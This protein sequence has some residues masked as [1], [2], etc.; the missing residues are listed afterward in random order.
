MI[1]RA[2]TLSQNAFDAAY[3]RAAAFWGCVP[4]SEKMHTHADLHA[5]FKSLPTD[6]TYHHV[7]TSFFLDDDFGFMPVPWDMRWQALE[8]HIEAFRPRAVVG[9][10]PFAFE[11]D[12]V[13]VAALHRTHTLGTTVL[14]GNVPLAQEMLRKL[15][16]EHVIATFGT[17]GALLS[18][19]DMLAALP[20]KVWQIVV[21]ADEGQAHTQL[22]GTV[23]KDLHVVPGH[24]IA[25][26]CEHLKSAEFH[27]SPSYA[28]HVEGGEVF[29]TSLEDVPAPLFRLRALKGAFS[30]SACRC[31]ATHTLTLI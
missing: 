8:R 7:P 22:P 27:P 16:A 4:D 21:R 6:A 18:G 24:S 30:Q 23:L 15:G 13:V 20:V 25:W 2:D 14:P 26:Q 9:Y 11:A 28:W 17:A 10:L 31:G 12:P 29:V 5:R 1:V 3:R 19:L